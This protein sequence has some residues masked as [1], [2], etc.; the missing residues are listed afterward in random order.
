MDKELFNSFNEPLMPK[1]MHSLML[2]DPHYK[3]IKTN[4]FRKCQL[5]DHP[6]IVDLMNT[7]NCSKSY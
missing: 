7:F 2:S 3:V 1:P 5:V 4:S 6:R